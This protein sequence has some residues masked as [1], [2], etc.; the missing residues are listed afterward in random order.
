[1]PA[2]ATTICG[3]VFYDLDRHVRVYGEL[4]KKSVSGT[5]ILIVANAADLGSASVAVSL[6]VVGA[7]GAGLE[8]DQLSVDVGFQHRF[9]QA[10]PIPG[11]GDEFTASN[12]PERGSGESTVGVSLQWAFH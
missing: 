8:T 11:G 1:M 4:W 10:S 2:T 6:T 3:G 5:E 9:I 7:L 12:V